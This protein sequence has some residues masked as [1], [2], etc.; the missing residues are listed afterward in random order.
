MFYVLNSL[1]I[2]SFFGCLMLL[3]D[4]GGVFGAIAW[5]LSVCPCVRVSGAPFGLP[6]DLGITICT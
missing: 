1:I 5:R 4:G 2:F 3:V 6:G